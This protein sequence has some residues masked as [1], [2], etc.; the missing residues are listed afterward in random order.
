[1]LDEDTQSHNTWISLF[2]SEFEML[3]S[4]NLLRLRIIVSL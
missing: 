2:N 3:E 1:M 4:I